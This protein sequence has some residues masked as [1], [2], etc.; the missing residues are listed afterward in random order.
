VRKKPATICTVC[1]KLKRGTCP[2]CGNGSARWGSS[3]RDSRIERGY[4][5]HWMKRR[6]QKVAANPLCEECE[7][8]G[9]VTI[10]KQVHHIKAFKSLA[11][12]LRL[13][14]DNLMSV[15]IPCHA[16]LTGGRNK[17]SR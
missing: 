1:G 17:R 12:P 2:H 9:R 14:W 4:D 15:C 5:K 13:A 16:V 7:R 11:D 3:H 10:T 6:A 8:H